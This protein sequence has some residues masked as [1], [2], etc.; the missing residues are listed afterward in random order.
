MKLLIRVDG[1]P[2]VGGGHIMRCLTL[3]DAAR[4]RGWEAVF[5]C[6]DHAGSLIEVVRGRGFEVIALPRGDLVPTG[7]EYET[8]LGAAE[9]KDVSQTL[10]VVASQSPDWLV[11][12]HYGVGKDWLAAMPEGVLVAYMDDLARVDLACDLVIDQTRVAPI[13]YGAG[14]GRV[15]SG[16]MAAILRPEF[17][18]GARARSRLERLLVAPG[19]GDA[20]GLARLAVDATEGLGLEAVDVVVGP[21]AGGIEAL[22]E[23][24][25]ARPEVCLHEN[26]ADMAELIAAADLAV[27][28]G[29]MS[30]WERCALGL[31]AVV[32]S[33]AD[34]QMRICEELE[35]SGAAIHVPGRPR[36]SAMDI[37]DAITRA[38]VQALGQASA[39][40]C[41][42]R[43]AERVLDALVLEA[44]AS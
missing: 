25:A 20:Y 41:D 22:R 27:G 40:L 18:R 4:V 14:V 9:A 10:A 37:R 3:A 12:D 31:G 11:V 15:L 38:D 16:P 6:R 34:N 21:L 39:R 8:W 33:V 7:A 26:I 24:A 23:L 2:V 29:G 1:A 28:A 43:G 5:V 32:V 42:G 19:M 13:E 36:P 44:R 30:S 35:A 17:A